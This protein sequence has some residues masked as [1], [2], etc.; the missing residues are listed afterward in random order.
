MET[1]GDAYMCVSGVPERNGDRH[2]AEIANMALD[3]L[4]AT[5]SFRVRH[6]PET[7]LQLRIGLYPT[8]CIAGGGGLSYSSA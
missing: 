6:R 4:E 3:L 2:A 1:I 8:H 5:R 7:Q